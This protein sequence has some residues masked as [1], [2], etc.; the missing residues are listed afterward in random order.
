VV[1]L[2]KKQIVLRLITPPKSIKGP[3]W[4]REYGILKRLM[5]KYPNEDF[6]QKIHFENDW[7]SL[8]I[9]QSDYGK[10]L[11]DKKYK[12][13]HYKI[14]KYK[15]IELTNKSGCDKVIIHKPKT[16]R[17]FLNE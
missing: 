7:D 9:L 17:G 14:P 3:F 10:S 13:F 11:L 16:I 1:K 15:K 4:T 2:N 6:W 8:V 5:E 12:E